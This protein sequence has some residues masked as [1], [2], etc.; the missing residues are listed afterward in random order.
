MYSPIGIYQLLLR[1]LNLQEITHINNLCFPL[2][3]GEISAPLKNDYCSET[4]HC[5]SYVYVHT[6]RERKHFLS[7]D[8]NLAGADCHWCPSGLGSTDKIL[9]EKQ[10]VKS[11]EVVLKF[12]IGLICRVFYHCLEV[13]EGQEE[14]SGN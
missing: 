13:S 9:L 4:I 1:S 12:L 10:Q 11:C 3:E 6:S 2:S 5:L 14:H 8:Q 7:Q